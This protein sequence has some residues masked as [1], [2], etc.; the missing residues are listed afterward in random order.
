PNKRAAATRAPPKETRDTKASTELERE[1]AQ[2]RNLFLQ[3]K[4]DHGCDIMQMACSRFDDLSY[5]VSE[6]AGASDPALLKR[7]KDM[8][9]M[10][11]LAKR[12][13]E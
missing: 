1:W 5:D 12:G 13:Q 2:T 9:E 6:N 4:R 7:V 11:R 10:L 8:Y 3:L